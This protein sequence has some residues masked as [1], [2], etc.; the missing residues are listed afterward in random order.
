MPRLNTYPTLAPLTCRDVAGPRARGWATEVCRQRSATA[1]SEREQ[2]KTGRGN[3][4]G[5]ATP[6]T[7]QKGSGRAWAARRPMPRELLPRQSILNRGHACTPAPRRCPRSVHLKTRVICRGRHGSGN[8][9]PSPALR[10]AHRSQPR[11]RHRQL[12]QQIRTVLVQR[13]PWGKAAQM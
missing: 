6:T 1:A 2:N 11:A 3:A 4:G 13:Y 10:V 7:P 8:N 12:K 9:S 5:S